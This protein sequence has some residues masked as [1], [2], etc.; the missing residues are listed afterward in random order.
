MARNR[1]I[2]IARGGNARS[3]DRRVWPRGQAPGFHPGE[4]GS[5]PVARSSKSSAL[6]Q[7]AAGSNPARRAKTALEGVA[8]AEVVATPGT[9]GGGA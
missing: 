8:R 6:G 4:A 2:Q 7:G 3:R 5:S 1:I 9:P